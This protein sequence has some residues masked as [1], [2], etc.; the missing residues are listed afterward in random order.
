MRLLPPLRPLRNSHLLSAVL[1]LVFPA[2]MFSLLRHATAIS[3]SKYIERM[4]P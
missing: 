4:G 1:Q 2:A 3:T